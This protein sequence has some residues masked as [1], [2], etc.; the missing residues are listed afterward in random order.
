MSKLDAAE[1]MVQ[2]AI[3]LIQFDIEYKPRTTIKAQALANFI[4]EF[5]MT[6]LDPKAEYWMIYADGSFVAGLGGVGVIIFSLEK[7][8]SQIWG[9]ALVPD[10]EQ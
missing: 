2:W 5:T 8:C 4:A 7:G 10:Y 9:P 3:E 1:R 6:D